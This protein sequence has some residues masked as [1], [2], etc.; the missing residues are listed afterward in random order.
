MEAKRG[1]PTASVPGSRPGSASPSKQPARPASAGR[2]LLEVRV[3][4]QFEKDPADWTVLE[5]CDWLEI[6]GL[7]QYRRRFVHHAVCGSLL[8]ALGPEELKTELGIGP[9]GHR[10]GLLTAIHD[11][12]SYWA[13]RQAEGSKEGYT[14]GSQDG[15]WEIRAGRS[16]ARGSGRASGNRSP[17]PPVV[18]GDYGLQRAYAQRARLMRDLEKAEAREAQR[19]KA[20]EQAQRVAGQAADEVRKLQASI[21]ELDR[22]LGW[23]GAAAEQ[24]FDPLDVHGAVAWQPAGTQRAAPRPRGRPGSAS[25]LLLGGGSPGGSA[26]GGG[27]MSPLSRRIMESSGAGGS[28]LQRLERDIEQRQAARTVRQARAGRYV[29]GSAEQLA[30]REQERRALSFVRELVETRNDELAQALASGD[31]ERVAQACG[32]IAEAYQQELGLSDDAAAAVKRL[33]SPA[34]RVTRLAGAMRSAQFMAR[35][36][37][38]LATRETRLQELQYKY[39]KLEQ[40]NSAEQQEKADA[41]AA[42]SHFVQLGWT[43]DDLCPAPGDESAGCD[44]LLGVL[45]KRAAALQEARQRGKP[46]VDW[47]QPEWKRDRL[48]ELQAERNAQLAAAM[49]EQAAAEAAEEAATPASKR[50]LLPL[51]K[52]KELPQV[53]VVPGEHLKQTVELLAGCR[54][55]EVALLQSLTGYRKLL[56]SWRAVRGQKFVAFTR[57]DLEAR[58]IK[59][60][61][62]ERQ[63]YPD[64]SR[65]LSKAE[66]DAFYDRLFADTERRARNRDELAE[67]AKADA[68]AKLMK[69]APAPR[70][71]PASAAAGSAPQSGA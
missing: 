23:Q 31:P 53:C 26:G 47:D 48:D 15:D 22:S 18:A 60:T 10:E 34:K 58:K 24:R 56:M 46:G 54:P 59:A 16:S 28:F 65:K 57:R 41:A 66:Q 13:Q 37:Q 11:L 71:R 35:L 30:E 36:Q 40:G 70:R 27:T 6:I 62:L 1:T 38:D 49:A 25:A 4:R 69:S 68:L 39:F 19:L 52:R 5:V 50:G 33:D 29:G 67:K 64:A 63:L 12:D 9:L 17:S 32:E 3:A 14:E 7:G 20:A 42:Q 8:L 44:K 45:L 61:E 51:P 21:C 2:P 43:A 55:A